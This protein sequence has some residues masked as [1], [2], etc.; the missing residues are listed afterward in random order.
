MINQFIIASSILSADFA[1]LREQI[2][3]AE[4]AGTDWIHIDV[5][6]GHF[7]PNLTIGPMIVEACR[8]VT[9][10]PLDVHLMIEQPE[11]LLKQFVDAGASSLTV[12]IET[13]P[14]IHRTLQSIHKMGIRAGVALNPGTPLAAITE[15]LSLADMILVMTVN[16]G[17]GGQQFIE[18]TLEKLTTLREWRNDNRT[19][20]LI[21]VDGGINSD[22]I[23]RTAEAGADVFVAGNAIFRH[24]DGI[25]AGIHALQRALQ[26][27]H[28][29]A[30]SK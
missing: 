25:S 24:P 30:I 4:N 1:C 11:K 18:T 6:D 15:V 3:Q 2:Q 22:T 13:C 23:A 20:A 27:A 21:E 5:M 16:P 7:V 19:H 14:H 26:S 29:D 8:R 17:F 9:D 12:H 28:V 10:I